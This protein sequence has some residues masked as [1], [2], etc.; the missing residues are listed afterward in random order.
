MKKKEFVL[1]LIFQFLNTTNVEQIAK[2][3]D[4][5][6]R[7]IDNVLFNYNIS[8]EEEM[9]IPGNDNFYFHITNSKNDLE[10]LKGN[11]NNKTNKFSIIDLGECEDL[12]KEKY[13]INKKDSLLILK[14]E[15]LTNI[16]S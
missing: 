1:T 2:N 6:Q 3:E 11:N 4:V 16:S 5:Y 10:N 9:I 15:K 13:H 8:N 12:L 7:I 14:L